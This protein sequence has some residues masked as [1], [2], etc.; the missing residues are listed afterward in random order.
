MN[1]ISGKALLYGDNIDTDVIIP[2][3]Y[4][5]T[6][7]VSILAEHAME[8]IDP[9]FK[10]KAAMCCILIAG[11]NFGCGSSR[12]HAALVLK[13]AGIRAIVAESYSRIF[14]RNAINQGIPTFE[15]E[16]P[17]NDFEQADDL[18]LDLNSWTLRNLSKAKSIRLRHLP[19]FLMDILASGG[20]VNYLKSRKAW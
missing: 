18:E 12:E 20:L 2:A 19:D 15:L 17:S 8:D 3:R 7:D 6:I 14:F 16:R 1:A 13:A 5:T 11:K 10:K 4:L 9:D